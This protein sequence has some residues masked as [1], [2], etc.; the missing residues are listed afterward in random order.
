VAAKLIFLDTTIIV[1]NSYIKFN[2]YHKTFSG[3]YLN[4]NS[5]HPLSQKRG[6]IIDLVDRFFLLSHLEFHKK[7]IKHVIQILLD[8]D[9][10]L[11]F[12]FNTILKRIKHLVNK[13]PIA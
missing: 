7:N 12:I 6:T 13:K 8:S 2:I 4:F 5:Q 9:Y 1:D 3:R 10:P 11:Q